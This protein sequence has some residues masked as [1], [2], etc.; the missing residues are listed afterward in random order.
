MKRKFQFMYILKQSVSNRWRVLFFFIYFYLFI[1]YGLPVE[2]L[3][4]NTEKK[5]QKRKQ[6][7][8][9]K[10]QKLWMW[11]KCV[12]HKESLK[13]F[14]IVPHYQDGWLFIVSGCPIFMENLVFL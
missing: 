4:C 9:K 5:K 14:F 10:N 2:I 8:N 6:K 7:Q 11:L 13:Y 12:L 3:V 1:F